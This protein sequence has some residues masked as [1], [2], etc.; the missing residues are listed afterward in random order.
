MIDKYLMLIRDVIGEASAAQQAMTPEK[1]R[2]N[3]LKQTVKRSQQYLRQERERQRQK[4]EF[5]RRRKD[6]QTGSGVV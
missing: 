3:A 5:E 6:L 4:K 1:A 2:I